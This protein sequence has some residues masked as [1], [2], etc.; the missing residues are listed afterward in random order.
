MKGIMVQ[1]SDDYW[2]SY[3]VSSPPPC[4]EDRRTI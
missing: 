4:Q 1:L 3:G 2:Q